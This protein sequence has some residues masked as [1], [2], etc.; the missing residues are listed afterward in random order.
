[1]DTVGVRTPVRLRVRPQER[2]ANH[3]ILPCVHAPEE[4]GISHRF[5]SLGA[6][7]VVACRPTWPRGKSAGVRLP[8]GD[9]GQCCSPLPH[10]M[11]PPKKNKSG[12]CWQVRCELAS[13]FNH[14]PALG[15]S[16][17]RGEPE[18]GAP[19]HPPAA[20]KFG[21]RGCARAAQPP[22]VKEAPHQPAARYHNWHGVAAAAA[23]SGSGASGAL[24]QQR[25]LGC[26][27]C[28]S[29]GRR[30]ASRGPE[31]L[32]GRRA[33][34]PIGVRRR[35]TRR[36]RLGAQRQRR[37]AALAAPAALAAAREEVRGVRLAHEGGGEHGGALRAGRARDRRAR[38]AQQEANP[39][40]NPNP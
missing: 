8:A 38:P 5:A 25:R 15:C 40:P 11:F 6:G 13:R 23:T 14:V 19:R 34:H 27:F 3:K 7:E 28:C 17:V 22:L 20:G 4:A 21:H 16:H 24:Q 30:S 9:H 2:E 12:C 33:A 36:E 31:A 18:S 10:S 35:A 26:V 32:A 29:A 1:M 39:N 37:V